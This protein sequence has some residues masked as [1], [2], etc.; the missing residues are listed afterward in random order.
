MAI[1]CNNYKKDEAEESIESENGSSDDESNNPFESVW[2][3]DTH[4][5]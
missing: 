1:T 5:I 4:A 2:D 3:C